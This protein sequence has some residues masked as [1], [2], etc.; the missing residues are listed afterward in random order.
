MKTLC[1][2]DLQEFYMKPNYSWYN[3]VIKNATALIDKYKKKGHPIILVELDDGNSG[4]TVLPIQQA[5]NGA[6]WSIVYKGDRSG[7]YEIIQA[8]TEKGFPL[9]FEVAGVN[10]HQ[11]VVATV[12]TLLMC[13]Y[14]VNVYKNASN[15]RFARYEAYQWDSIKHKRDLRIKNV[16]CSKVFAKLPNLGTGV[17]GTNQ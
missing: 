15:P 8:A 1:L 12:N 4:Q 5:L 14:P 6:N 10:Y 17:T 3:Q 16:K 13:G 11:C 7:G 2:I 9:S